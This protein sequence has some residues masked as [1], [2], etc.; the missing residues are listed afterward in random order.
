MNDYPMFGFDENGM[1]ALPFLACQTLQDMIHQ[2]DFMVEDD[3]MDGQMY[4]NEEN[5]DDQG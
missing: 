3:P 2:T 5:Y 1:P 4:D